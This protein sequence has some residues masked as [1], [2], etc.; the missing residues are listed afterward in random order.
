MPNDR[1]N[2]PTPP[3]LRRIGQTG[4]GRPVLLCEKHA[5]WLVPGEPTTDE[6]CAAILKRAAMSTV[7]ESEVDQVLVRP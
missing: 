3:Y 2:L 1:D 6:E 7:A 4:D 5:V